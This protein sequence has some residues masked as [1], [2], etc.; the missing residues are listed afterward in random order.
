[1]SW[2]RQLFTELYFHRLAREVTK[3]IEAKKEVT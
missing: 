2:S 3:V 1:M